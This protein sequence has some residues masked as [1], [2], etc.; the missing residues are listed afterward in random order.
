MY[1]NT[2]ELE[3]P[4]QHRKEKMKLKE[5]GSLTSN[6]TTKLQSSRHYDTG[7]ENRNTDQ[8][9]RIESPEINPNTYGQLAY[10]KGA[11]DI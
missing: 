2:K 11:K 4:K 8:C 5:S 7:T 10:D 9:N 3:H 1:G 6:P